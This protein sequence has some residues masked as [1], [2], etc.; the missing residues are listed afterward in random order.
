MEIELTILLLH[1]NTRV[2][3]KYFVN[4]CLGKHLLAS[5]LTL[6]PSKFKFVDNFVNLSFN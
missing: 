3:F 1:M 5:N 6:D 4:D 2:C